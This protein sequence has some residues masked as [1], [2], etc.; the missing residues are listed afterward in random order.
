MFIVVS[1]GRAIAVR[2]IPY[3]P[4]IAHARKTLRVAWLALDKQDR[5]WIDETW[6]VPETDSPQPAFRCFSDILHSKLENQGQLWGAFHCIQAMFFGL[7]EKRYRFSQTK[8]MGLPFLHTIYYE[9]FKKGQTIRVQDSQQAQWLA[10]TPL[11]TVQGAAVSRHR[12]IAL[13]TG[14]DNASYYPVGAFFI[15]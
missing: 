1:A 14:G 6:R 8:E 11:L 7:R 3:H 4:L 5:R 2:D 13:P 10:S 15:S 12:A 9:Q